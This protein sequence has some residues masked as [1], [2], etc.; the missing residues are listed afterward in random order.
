MEKSPLESYIA[1][2]HKST[3]FDLIVDTE[4]AI[5]KGET[6]TA[7]V[8]LGEL[9]GLIWLMHYHIESLERSAALVSQ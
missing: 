8:H 2:V 9:R 3:A 1:D 7:L 6:A 5:Q 4:K